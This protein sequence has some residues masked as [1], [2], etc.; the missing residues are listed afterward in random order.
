MVDDAFIKDIEIFIQ[1]EITELIQL[2]CECSN[3]TLPDEFKIDFFGIYNNDSHIFRFSEYEHDLIRKI[4]HHINGIVATEQG[5]AYFS[6]NSSNTSYMIWSDEWYFRTKPVQPESTAKNDATNT[7]RFLYKL[8]EI[9]NQNATRPKEGYRFDEDTK[10][11]AS[12]LRMIAGRLAYETLQHNLP[13]ALPSLSTTDRFINQ[14]HHN[15]IE[16]E[17]RCNELVS[18]LNDRKLPLFVSLSEDATRVI[19]RVQYDSSTKFF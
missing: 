7:H 19:N 11:H 13:H 18:Y 4:V 14:T 5:L 10:S 15:V 6:V 3:L 17:L 9:A 2:K 1:D 8:L 16:G 12:F